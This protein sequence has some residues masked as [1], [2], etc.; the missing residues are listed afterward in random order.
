MLLHSQYTNRDGT[1]KAVSE[2]KTCNLARVPSHVV[3]TNKN[4]DRN[5]LWTFLNQ[6]Q[7]QMYMY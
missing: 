2:W 1:R 7:V 5:A 3:M 6:A 4:K